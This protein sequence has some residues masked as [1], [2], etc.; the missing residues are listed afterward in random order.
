M[1]DVR[2]QPVRVWLWTL[3]RC[4]SAAIVLLAFGLVASVVWVANVSRFHGSFLFVLCLSALFG[5]VGAAIGIYALWKLRGTPSD[6]PSRTRKQA[7]VLVEGDY[8]NVLAACRRAVAHLGSQ[9]TALDVD[10]GRLT[11]KTGMSWRSWGEKLTVSVE[12]VAARQWRVCVASD[13]VLPATLLDWG[14]NGMNV[15]YIV[16]VMTNDSHT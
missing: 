8:E 3:L 2:P 7:E 13:S 14:K 5:L 4:A 1:K 11:A 6:T 15:R 16:D 12:P 9:M 10:G